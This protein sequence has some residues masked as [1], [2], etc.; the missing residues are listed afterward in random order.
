MQR[1]WQRP[2]RLTAIILHREHPGHMP[3]RQ[4]LRMPVFVAKKSQYRNC[5][6]QERVAFGYRCVGGCEAEISTSTSLLFELAR[7]RRELF[8]TNFLYETS[9]PAVARC[10][11]NITAGRGAMLRDRNDAAGAE[12]SPTMPPW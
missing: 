7:R 5:Q 2:E 6:R 3:M 8:A 9:N 11:A 4:T 10:R 12:N 1:P